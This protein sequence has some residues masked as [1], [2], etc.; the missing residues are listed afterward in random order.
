MRSDRDEDRSLVAATLSEPVQQAH[1][2]FPASR[3]NLV[4]VRRRFG[5]R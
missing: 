4:V 3:E 2:G 5:V 1:A